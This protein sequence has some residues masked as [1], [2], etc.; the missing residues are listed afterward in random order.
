[1]KFVSKIKSKY[2]LIEGVLDTQTIKRTVSELKKNKKFEDLKKYY[3]TVRKDL[4][5]R[6]NLSQD[7]ASS[8]INYA[9]HHH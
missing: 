9:I 6:L 8:V 5:D 2:I 3:D 1:M 4:V 7:E